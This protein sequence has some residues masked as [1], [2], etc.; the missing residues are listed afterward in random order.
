LYG[1][2]GADRKSTDFYVSQVI[3]KFHGTQ[4]SYQ[5]S[6]YTA[7]G[8]YGEREN[9]IGKNRGAMVR[10]REEVFFVDGL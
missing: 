2:A 3:E 5:I 9:K 7:F 8:E 1:G 10:R 6:W 4:L